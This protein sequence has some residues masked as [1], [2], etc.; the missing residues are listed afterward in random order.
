MDLR[1]LLLTFHGRI[2]RKDYWI[3]TA[4]LI[5]VTLIGALVGLFIGGAIG[6]P[7]GATILLGLIGL[8]VTAPGL[9]VALKRSNDRGYP[10][11][12]VLAIFSVS[13]AYQ[14]VDFLTLGAT[15][16]T[17]LRIALFITVIGGLW[18]LVDLGF[19]RGVAGPNRHG[20]DPSGR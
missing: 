12:P 13:I 20:P 17:T 9:A 11:E 14:L 7:I 19:M 10:P 5:V 1:A 8:A 2:G 3:G 6:G 16:G 18:M 4:C 15:A